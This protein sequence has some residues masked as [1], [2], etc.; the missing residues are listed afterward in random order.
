MAKGSPPFVGLT[1]GIG[2]GKSEALKALERLGAATLST[3]AVVHEL[4]ESD[5]VRALLVER[6]G[7]RVAPGGRIDRNAV[8]AVVF[9]D[10]DER[11][12]LEGV[13][14]PRVGERVN[15][16]REEIAHRDPPPRAAVVEVP[17]LFE[18]GME[19][20][21]DHTIAV[22]AHEEVRRERA[23]ARGHTAVESRTARQ[24]SQTEKAERAEFV[25]SNDG[26]LADLQQELSAVLE[27]IGL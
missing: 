5:E 17:L 1:G 21:F 16:W 14:W 18:S 3:D 15:R 7:D 11:K 10:P 26:N 19:A 27:N 4:L 25:I 22:V 20:V 8:A 9:E 2:A 6:F 24:L 13:L 23:A 12:W